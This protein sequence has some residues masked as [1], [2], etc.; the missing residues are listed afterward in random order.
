MSNPVALVTGAS[1]G[2]GRAICI[3]LADTGMD[4]VGVARGAGA[5]EALQATL[6]QGSRRF[7]AVPADLASDPLTAVIDKAWQWQGRVHV[8]V[9]AA[10]VLIRKP[11]AELSPAEWDRTFALNARVPFFL[12]EGLGRRMF[13]AGGGAIVNVASIAGERVTGAPAPYQASKAAL[14]QLTRFYAKHLAPR[15]RVNAV[16]PG[17]VETELSRAWLADP[18][19]RAWVEERTPLGR[20]AV[21]EE[22]AAVVRFLAAD[23]AKFVTGQHLMVDGGWSVA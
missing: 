17:Y 2:I 22:V 13:D 16:G 3:A 19:N 11:E 8:L 21:P 15:V 5:L 18:A 14:L 20:L 6:A 4:V 10:G 12:M 1:R 23:E 9:N 7:L